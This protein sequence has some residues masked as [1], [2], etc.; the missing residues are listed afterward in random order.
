MKTD[1]KDY[2]FAIVTF[3][4][5]VVISI[6]G[7]ILSYQNFERETKNYIKKVEESKLEGIN[8]VV[9]GY[10]NLAEALSVVALLDEDLDNFELIAKHI[11]EYKS[12]NDA[13]VAS[14]LSAASMVFLAPQGIVSKTYSSGNVKF[15]LKNINLY[16]YQY[17]HDYVNY[18]VKNKLPAATGKVLINSQNDNKDGA[19]EAFLIIM[20]VVNKEN[21]IWGFAGVVVDF[22]AFVELCD[23]S[24]I[25]TETKTDLYERNEYDYALYIENDEKDK[26]VG[27]VSYSDEKL[28]NYSYDDER[29]IT[30]QISFSDKKWILAVTPKDGIWASTTFLRVEAIV[31]LFISILITIITNLLISYKKQNSE[32]LKLSYRDALTGLLNQRAFM[33]DL[34]ELEKKGSYFG[35]MFVDLD[36]FKKIN[37]DYGHAAGDEV[38]IT[39][40]NRVKE[41][42][43][44][45]GRVYRI[46]GDEFTVIIEVDRD[47]EYYIELIEKI[48]NLVTKSIVI[49]G[50]EIET[51]LSTG[52]ARCPYDGKNYEEILKVADD[53]MYNSK[54]SKKMIKKN[55]GKDVVTGLIMMDTFRYVAPQIISNMFK[56]GKQEDVVLEHINIRGFETYNELNGYPKGYKF[57]KYIADEIIGLFPD[58]LCTR[59]SENN[60]IVILYKNE[61]ELLIRHLNESIRNHELLDSVRVQAG[62]YVIDS[63]ENFDINKVCN[64]ARIACDYI[65]DK[66][67]T[68]YE[69]YTYEM[70]EEVHDVNMILSNFE[71]AL[72][73][74][75]I[76]LYFQPIMRTISGKVNS[77]EVLSRW[78]FSED[79]ILQPKEFIGVLEQFKLIHHLDLYILEESCKVY[80]TAKAKGDDMPSFSIN[81][82]KVDFEICDICKYIEEITDMYNVPRDVVIIEIAE[83]SLGDEKGLVGLGIKRLRS[84]GFKIHLDDFGS[85]FSVLNVLNEYDLDVI[86]LDMKYMND[87]INDGKAKKILLSMVDMAKH[88]QVQTLC[89]GVETSEQ[90]EFAK[91]IGCDFVQ[92]FLSGKSELYEDMNYDIIKGIYDLEDLETKSYYD[93]I[94]R[95]NFQSFNPAV[96]FFAGE[97]KDI[98]IMSMAIIEV[99][100]DNVRYLYTSPQ[101]LKLISDMGYNSMDMEEMQEVLKKKIGERKEILER[102]K[103]ADKYEELDFLDYIGTDLTLKIIAVKIAEN[104]IKN[105]HAFVVFVGNN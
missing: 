78:Y 22:N 7:F 1:I 92:G 105:A 93:D 20:P 17:L 9:S 74:K 38:L 18:S 77:L 101:Y 95:V 23:F 15:S 19:F 51:D 69:Y 70:G 103:N 27:V 48:R 62:I 98:N 11:V 102:C 89:E 57:L 52:Y 47:R 37:D 3:V 81:F 64:K 53:A 54:G 14:Y 33:R 34:K 32:N 49:N 58:R 6:V 76:K 46:G 71:K 21:E 83:N 65:R 96:A 97:E 88:L 42:L 10:Y 59:R 39:T 29:Y 90:F 72:K 16:T 75:D 99:L 8:R 104:S 35:V 28:L 50:E 26:N 67:N 24:T 73:K 31:F 84:G 79:K 12:E 41:V 36:E 68:D 2:I 87:V 4:I 85:G 44:E 45:E 86:K 82:S 40:S 100:E 25:T 13:D 5:C 63:L 66:I 94:G 61:A 56:K 30:S 91:S 43:G 60:F 55:T 80:S